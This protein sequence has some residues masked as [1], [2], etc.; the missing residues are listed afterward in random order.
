MDGKSPAQY[1]QLIENVQSSLFEIGNES[2]ISKTREPAC[3][4]VQSRDE[5]FISAVVSCSPKIS[6]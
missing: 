4:K 6:R 2:N 1:N 3:Y 5:E